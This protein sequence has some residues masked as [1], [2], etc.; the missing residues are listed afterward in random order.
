MVKTVN[1]YPM[2]LL[3][4]IISAKFRAYDVVV[5]SRRVSGQNYI[6]AAYYRYTLC[7]D[8]SKHFCDWYTLL[9]Y[10]VS[11]RNSMFLIPVIE[12]RYLVLCN[13]FL[14]ESCSIAGRAV[15]IDASINALMR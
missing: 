4:E 13:S 2:C 15:T 7:V 11:A 3:C 8:I 12:K 10:F 1:F 5:V 6:C 14:V 9:K